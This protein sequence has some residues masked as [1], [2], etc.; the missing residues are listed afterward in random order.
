MTAEFE[1]AASVS[2]ETLLGAQAL[3]SQWLVSLGAPNDEELHEHRETE[4]AREAFAKLT[5]ASSADAQTGALLKLQTPIAVQRLTGMLC[6]YDWEFVHQAKEL[7]SYA[8]GKILEETVH[9][10]ARVRLRALELLGKVT[11]VGLF[12]DRIE[13]KKVEVGDRDLE[14]RIREKLEKLMVARGQLEDVTSHTPSTSLEE[15]P[16]ADHTPASD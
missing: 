2:P 9:V 14:N 10:D 6:A 1:A 5:S 12:T 16:D 13:V 7:R 8:V 11:E 4:A 3:T 15:L